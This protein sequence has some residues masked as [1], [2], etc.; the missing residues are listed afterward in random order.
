[1]TEYMGFEQAIYGQPNELHPLASVV[2]NAAE[3]PPNCTQTEDFLP[4]VLA[5]VASARDC[6]AKLTIAN[7][8]GLL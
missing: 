7:I 4:S 8:D 3:G 6:V 5:L 1:M 2:Y